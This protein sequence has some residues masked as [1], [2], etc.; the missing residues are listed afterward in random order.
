MKDS[1]RIINVSFDVD[2]LI[3]DAP[4]PTCI[5]NELS[6]VQYQNL[7]ILLATMWTNLRYVSYEEK[8]DGKQR[9]SKK[10]SRQ[11]DI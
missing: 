5:F 1:G 11:K 7:L 10:K 4:C 6:K 2:N 9:K 3:I 8:K